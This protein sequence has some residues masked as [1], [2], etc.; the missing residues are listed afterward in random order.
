[1]PGTTALTEKAEP[2]RPAGSLGSVTKVSG[3]AAPTARTGHRHAAIAACL[4]F[5]RPL[6]AQPDPDQPCAAVLVLR[7]A[8]V[9]L[10]APVG[11]RVILD[12]ASGQRPAGRPGAVTVADRRGRA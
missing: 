1:V 2:R 6:D 3:R 11:H 10:A 9:R 12:A 7:S 5:S 4:A 8:T